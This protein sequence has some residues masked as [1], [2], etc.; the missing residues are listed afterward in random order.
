MLALASE[1]KSTAK[2]AL[3]VRNYSA[4]RGVS[5]RVHRITALALLV[6]GQSLVA[7][8]DPAVALMPAFATFLLAGTLMAK[9]TLTEPR[10]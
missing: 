7:M 5:M 4:A 8:L 3:L 10:Q 2:Q 1:V 6:V 9:Q